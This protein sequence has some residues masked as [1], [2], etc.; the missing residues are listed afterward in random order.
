M[1]IESEGKGMERMTRT[2]CSFSPEGK[3]DE[4]KLKKVKAKQSEGVIFPSF[5][6]ED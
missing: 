3:V 6:L 4:I 2:D 5:V 1:D